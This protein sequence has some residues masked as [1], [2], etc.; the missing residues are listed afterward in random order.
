[1]KMKNKNGA[2]A[3]FWPKWQLI[4]L[5]LT[6]PRRK[7]LVFSGKILWTLEHFSIHMKMARSRVL[8]RVVW[9]HTAPS[10][11]CVSTGASASVT[12]PTWVQKHFGSVLQPIRPLFVLQET[13]MNGVYEHFRNGIFFP[14]LLSCKQVAGSTYK[15]ERKWHIISM[16]ISKE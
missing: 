3:V 7:K 10:P 5:N 4:L 16:I 14:P 13:K 11:V 8:Q 1:M 12:A 6:R 15:K 9:T 2:L